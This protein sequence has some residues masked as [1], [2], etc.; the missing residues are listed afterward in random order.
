MCGRNCHSFVSWTFQYITQIRYNFCQFVSVLRAA[1]VLWQCCWLSITVIGKSANLEVVPLIPFTPQLNPGPHLPTPYKRY[2]ASLLYKFLVFV[3]METQETMILTIITEELLHSLSLVSLFRNYH[4]PQLLTRFDKMKF[5]ESLQG[6]KR[7]QVC[8]EF[9]CLS[10][11]I[12][13]ATFPLKFY[14]RFE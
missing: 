1:F 11:D 12:I 10:L 7:K 13:L 8:P 4:I 2:W 14:S 3:R 5:K 9:V 6:V